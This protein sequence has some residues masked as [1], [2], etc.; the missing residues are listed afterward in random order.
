M[1]MFSE[2]AK[3]IGTALISFFAV[4]ILMRGRKEGFKAFIWVNKLI[5]GLIDGRNKSPIISLTEGEPEWS[6][7]L[8]E[9]G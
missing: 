4:L 1:N 9:L 2:L 5:D 8:S 3:W 7:K 6:H